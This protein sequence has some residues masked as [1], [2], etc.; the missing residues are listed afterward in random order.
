MVSRVVEP[1]VLD[2]AVSRIPLIVDVDAHVV[3]P[4][5]VWSS[6]LPARFRGVGPRIV[7][8]PAGEVRLVG[9]SYLEA[10]GTAGPDVAW[11]FYEDRRI[12][13][14]SYIAAAGMRAED[15]GMNGVTYED[16]RPGCWS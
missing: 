9:S 11:W 3:E 7:Y 16:I 12:S 6:R 13:I 4:A 8:A 10:P 2:S 1:G 14:K 15:V 5:H